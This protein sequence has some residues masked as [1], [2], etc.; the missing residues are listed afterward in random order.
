MITVI[1]LVGGVVGLA[2]IVAVLLMKMRQGKTEIKREV[3]ELGIDNAPDG[4]EYVIDGEEGGKKEE[5]AM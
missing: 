2:V 3:K 5:T 4:N 1:A